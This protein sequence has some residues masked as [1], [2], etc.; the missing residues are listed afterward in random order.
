VGEAPQ[1]VTARRELHELERLGDTPVTFRRAL[2]H[3]GDQIADA[4]GWVQRR[5]RILR[6]V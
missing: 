1:E 4:N 2:Q 5:G 6:D 3:R